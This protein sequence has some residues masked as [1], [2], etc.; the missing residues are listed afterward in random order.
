[1]P[2]SL[3]LPADIEAQI[4]GYGA[5]AGLTKSAVIVRSIQEFLAHHAE[6]TSAQIYEDAMRQAGAQDANNDDDADDNTTAAPLEQ[7]PLKQQARQAI[8]NKH[9]ERSQRA[10]HAL[11]TVGD[12]AAKAP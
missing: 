12:R 7:S 3:R 1:M 11:K 4:T 8:R 2:I 10:T 5:R 9:L 6:P